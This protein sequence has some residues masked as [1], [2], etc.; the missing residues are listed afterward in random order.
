MYNGSLCYV[1]VDMGRTQCVSVS[2]DMS[3][4]SL[5]YVIDDMGREEWVSVSL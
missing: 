3:K 4:G 1:I 5:C 2:S